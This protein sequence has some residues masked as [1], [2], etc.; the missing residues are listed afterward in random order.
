M[1]LLMQALKKAEHAKQKQD[2][3]ASADSPEE[4]SALQIQ[5][6]E[7]GLSPQENTAPGPAS[8]LDM[9]GMELSP[10]APESNTSTYSEP[11]YS[12]EQP[13]A[14]F[15]QP[16]ATDLTADVQPSAPVA[17][18]DYSDKQPSIQEQSQLLAA[19]MRLEQQKTAALESGKLAVEQQKAKTVFAS[20]QPRGNKRPIWIAVSG[21]AMVIL[22]LGGGYYYLQL[23]TQNTSTFVRPLPIQQAAATA[24]T[25]GPAPAAQADPTSTKEPQKESQAS[26]QPAS[27]QTSAIKHQDTAHAVEKSA[28]VT[29]RPSPLKAIRE[30]V[31]IQAKAATPADT[32]AIDIRQTTIDSHINPALGKAYQYFMNGDLA[33]AQ[34]QY[35]TVLQQDANNRDALLGMAAIAIQRRQDAQAGSFYFHLL[36]LDPNDPD[37]I[38]GIVSLQGGDPIEMESRLKKALAQNPQSG[39]LQF[40]LGNLYAK[41]SRWPD[42]QQSYFHAYGAEPGNPDY[43]LNLAVSLDRLNQEKL[44]LE[45]Y[46]R[47]LTLAESKPGNFNKVAIRERIKQLQSAA[48]S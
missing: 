4:K 24:A 25:P 47:A 18:H 36:E 40:A 10:V 27:A 16:V 19:K 39:A 12:P 8:N 48:G 34:Q 2:S 32:D 21:L 30:Q 45:F 13:A 3:S 38:A 33:A 17:A 7:L 15:K 20:K 35:Q 22:C 6:D 9:L 44:A 42:A 43:A 14:D 11:A 41:Q 28:H 31:S 1:S 46:Q 26:V 23:A 37:A 29:P 5:N